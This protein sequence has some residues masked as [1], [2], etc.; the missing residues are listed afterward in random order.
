MVEIFQ[1]PIEQAIKEL[2]DQ[3]PD[4]FISFNDAVHNI[5]VNLPANENP[6]FDLQLIFLVNQDGITDQ[7]A[8][9]IEYIKQFIPSC[10]DTNL[11]HLDPE[12]RIL[13]EEQISV[14]EFN[15]SRS[16]YFDFYTYQGDEIEGIE[17]FRRG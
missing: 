7:Q 9:A 11:I 13:T 8:D 14:K 5:R 12:I 3:N 2:K 17:P 6:P 16:M 4:I 15:A 1:K 10:L